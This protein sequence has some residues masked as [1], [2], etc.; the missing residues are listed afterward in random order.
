MFTDIVGYTALGQRNESASLAI[1]ESQRT[2]VRPILREHNGREVKTMGDSFLVEF[3]SALDAVRCSYAIQ[4]AVREVNISLSDDERIHLRIGIHLGD[5]VESE[6]DIAGDAVNIASRIE[7]LASDGGVCVSRPVYEQVHNKFELRMENMGAKS[8]KNVSLPLEVYQLVMPWDSRGSAEP[9]ARRLLETRRV[10]VMPL[11]NMISD[12]QDEYFADGMTE[13]LI[14]AISK[15]PELSVVSR[16]SVMQYKNHSKRATDI[17]DELNAGTLLE[18]SVRK[19]GNRVRITVQLIDANGDR[20]LW[21]EN[22]DRSLD[23]V[24]GIQSEI[25]KSVAQ[26]LRVKLLEDVKRR[27]ER[28]PTT[29]VEAH[30]LYLKGLFLQNRWMG[31]EVLKSVEFFKAAIARDPTYALAH[32][33]LSQSTSVM[34]FFGLAPSIEAFREAEK[35][36]RA[37]VSMDPYLAEAHLALGMAL[38]YQWDFESSGRELE[39]ALELNENLAEAHLNKASL[40]VFRRR[41]EQALPEIDRALELDPLSDTTLMHAATWYLYSGHV[42]EAMTRYKKFLAIDPENAFAINNLGLAHVRKGEIQMGL[43]ELERASRLR[44]DYKPTE[45]QDLAWALSKA[46]RLDDVRKILSRM[47]DW[48]KEHG[49]ASASIACVYSNLGDMDEAYD[50]LERAYEEHSGYLLAALSDFAFE[51]IQADPRFEA[52]SRKLGLPD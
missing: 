48:R 40:L 49:G 7:P 45:E 30:T 6:G 18:G 26:V 10:A 20:H 8:L 12:P 15:V 4:R 31:P 11:V 28:P 41:F 27:I 46:G 25:A 16:T 19:A 47:L 2:I 35:E 22:Y 1:V 5:I 52:F 17:G 21:A 38:F 14:S 36:A 32:A 13:E 33:R 50:W 34:G 24:F 39:R 23:D 9:Q 44:K 29:D 3:A 51:R 42:D 43:A 37:A